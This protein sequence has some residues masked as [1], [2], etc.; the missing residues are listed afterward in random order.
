MPRFTVI[1]ERDEDGMLVARVPSLRGC[2]TFPNTQDQLQT[3]VCEV[4]QK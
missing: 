2:H 4:I 1:V 3:R